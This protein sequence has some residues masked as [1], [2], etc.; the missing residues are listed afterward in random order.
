MSEKIEKKSKS[1]AEK[2]E[3]KPF[4]DSHIG[5]KEENLELED[6]SK[7]KHKSFYEAYKAM[8]TT[9]EEW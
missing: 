9:R 2:E 3:P 8:S 4:D 7:P 1:S 5:I 6:S